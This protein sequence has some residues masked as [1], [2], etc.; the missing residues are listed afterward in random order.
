MTR[1]RKR[2]SHTKE[3]YY[4]LCIVAVMIILLLSF[5]GPGGY[6]DLQKARLQVQQQ[7]ARVEA[8][9]AGNA[10]LLKSIQAL[11]SD[12]KAIEEVAREQGYAR[13]NEII[14]Q[15]RPSPEAPK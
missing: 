5:L 14:Q 6:R 2:I 4:I 7:R 15:V 9:K 3:L 12:G 8:L 13:G 11:Q 10:A 1:Q